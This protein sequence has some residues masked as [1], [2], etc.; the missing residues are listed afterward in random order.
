M[1]IHP[2]KDPIIYKSDAIDAAGSAS[3]LARILNISR[4][5]V[6]AWG[7]FAPSYQAYRLIQVFPGIK[8]QNT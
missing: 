3:K 6:S 8:K 2:I 1:I 7:Q 4:S 5:S